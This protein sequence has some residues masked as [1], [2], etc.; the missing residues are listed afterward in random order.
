MAKASVGSVI[1]AIVPPKNMFALEAFTKA[2]KKVAN[3][4]ITDV[5]NDLKATVETWSKKPRFT[6]RIENRG[7]DLTLIV[8]TKNKI[9]M[10]VDGGAKPHIIKPRRRKF[11]KF[12]PYYRAKTYPQKLQSYAGGKLS[13]IS[14]YRKRVKHPGFKARKFIRTVQNKHLPKFQRAVYDIVLKYNVKRG[15]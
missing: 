6:R 8:F 10:L 1:K 15:K 12:S 4:T 5:S 9:Y 2:L 14:V 3:K 13:G 7:G 11:L